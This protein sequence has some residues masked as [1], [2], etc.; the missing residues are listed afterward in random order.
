[1]GLTN[2]VMNGQVVLTK[3]LMGSYV[4]RLNGDI[5]AEIFD[6]LAIDL[7]ISLAK[8]IADHYGCELEDET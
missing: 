2:E 5:V 4:V 1:M 3:G 8:Q 7:I 6:G